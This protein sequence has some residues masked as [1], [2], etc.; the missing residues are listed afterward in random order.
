MKYTSLLAFICSMILSYIGAPMIMDML[1]KGKVLASNYKND[2]IPICMGLLFVFVQFITLSII[3]TIDRFNDKNIMAYLI[4]FIMM[5]LVGLID[6]LIGDKKIKGFKGHIKSFFRGNL[7]TGGMKAGVGFLVALFAS[8]ILTDN[9]IEIIINVFVIA[10]FTNL[11]N[12]FDLRPGR[13]IKVFILLS[14]IMLFTSIGDNYNFILFSFLGIIFVY[15]PLDLKAKA[16]MGDIGSN[17]MGLTLG[18]YCAL[19]HDIIIKSIYLFILAIIHILAER[20]S[21]SKLIENNKLLKFL[22]NIGR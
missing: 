20:L 17:V 9:L 3:M 10:L 21:F 19:T 7:T 8:S 1:I 14:I 22:D 6:D 2:E 16:M 13:S 15:L 5:G 12:L 4:T 11:I 18:V